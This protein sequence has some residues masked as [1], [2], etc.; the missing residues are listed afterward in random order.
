MHSD[1]TNSELSGRHGIYNLSR[2]QISR[3]AKQRFIERFPVNSE[4]EPLDQALAEMLGSC[5]KLG[6][7]QD[8]SSAYIAVCG[9]K[10]VVLIEQN[11]VILTFMTQDQFESVMVDFGRNRW[12]RKPGRWLKRIMSR[13]VGKWGNHP[14]L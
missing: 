1:G 8:G 7:K 9:E 13:R 11:Q 12:P 10:P 3:H 14:P 6:V 5:R 2:C 4:S